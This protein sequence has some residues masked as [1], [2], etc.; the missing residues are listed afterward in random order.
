MN[1]K[2]DKVNV[3]I[4]SDAD[5]YRFLLKTLSEQQFD[6]L[7]RRYGLNSSC[8][9]L[10]SIAQHYDLTRE[11]IRQ[12]ESQALEKCRLEENLKVFH[13]YLAIH[14]FDQ[15]DTAFGEA[16]VILKGSVNKLKNLLS[17]SYRLSIDVAYH[18]IS[19]WLDKCMKP[20]EKEGQH[21]GWFNP[22]V[23]ADVRHQ[24][25]V[26]SNI[27][28]NVRSSIQY[29]I[30]NTLRQA[31]W[32]VAIS[33][34]QNSLP[35][36][37]EANILQCLKLD[38]DAE[39]ENDEISVIRKLRTKIRVIMILRYAK[40]PLHTK[41]VQDYDRKLFGYETSIRDISAKLGRSKEI[42]IVDRGTYV[43]WEYIKISSSAVEHIRN[44]SAKQLDETGEFLSSK[45]L[46]MR[47]N[48]AL[49][50]EVS[51]Q[52]TNYMLY[53]ICKDDSRFTTRRGLMIGLTR[54]DFNQS[55]ISLTEL[56]HNVVEKKGP[57]SIA[58]IN[59]EIS[60]CR[61][62]FDANIHAILKNSS[63]IVSLGNGFYDVI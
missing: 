31:E 53:G 1:V 44:I 33:T 5:I 40:R 16:R 10:E 14:A 39:F 42:L 54:K 4:C 50:P 56:I 34:I 32:P 25:T 48:T 2:K 46:L 9:T 35:D 58:D 7:K 47:I 41:H 6:V 60:G 27:N 62:V 28:S 59:K 13:T 49:T 30:E 51:S 63:T 29:R 45:V 21:L 11:R 52:L 12:I 19:N 20:F 8:E 57:I 37:S 36:I 61:D 38:F 17:G 23:E 15:T 18:N 26:N 43:L 3:E 22:N 24:I 55:F